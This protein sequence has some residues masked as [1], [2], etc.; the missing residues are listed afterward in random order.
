MA[1][2][3]G[4]CY[5]CVSNSSSGGWKCKNKLFGNVDLSDPA[6]SNFRSDEARA[7]WECEYYEGGPY[8]WNKTGTC[9][10]KGTKRHDD[11]KACSSFYE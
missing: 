2:T 5:F 9:T 11:D 6:C 10:L 7:C 1:R 8:K 4:D 3:C